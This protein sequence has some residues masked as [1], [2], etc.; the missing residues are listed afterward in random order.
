MGL[1]SYTIELGD[2]CS[3]SRSWV[4]VNTS[5]RR[6][7]TPSRYVRQIVAGH[8]YCEG[9]QLAVFVDG[10]S[11][12]AAV[13]ATM[14]D[15]DT[16]ALYVRDQRRCGVVTGMNLSK[17]VVLDRRPPRSRK[18]RDRM[19]TGEHQPCGTPLDLQ[20]QELQ[21]RRQPSVIAQP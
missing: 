19:P 6:L 5:R 15:R 14:R 12:I 4:P 2:V 20:L 10:K 18:S 9:R 13:G 1:T 3:Y 17:A 11:T 8:S 7:E 21:S 16:D